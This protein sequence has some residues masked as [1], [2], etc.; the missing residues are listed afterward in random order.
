MLAAC[1][2]APK[3]VPVE[4]IAFPVVLIT[5]Q[6]PTNAAVHRADIE[7]GPRDLSLMRV[8]RYST[9]ASPPIVID[10]NARI[11][12]MNEI[13]GAHGGLWMMVNPTGLMPITF[14]LTERR[15]QGLDVARALISACEFLGRDID[16]E[17]R[18]ARVARLASVQS[19]PEMI[20]IIEEMPLPEVVN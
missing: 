16:S 15:E 3:V 9:L 6:T 12:D 1:A 7:L 17:R 2:Q 8:E 13:K 20:A 4:D 5:G 14:K 11:Y 18:E 19:M 10:S